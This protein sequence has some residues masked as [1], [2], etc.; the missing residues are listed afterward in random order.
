MSLIFSLPSLREAEFLNASRYFNRVPRSS[1]LAAG[2][3]AQR[4]SV[5][6]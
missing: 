3:I 6:L 1:Q 5:A 2:R 4:S